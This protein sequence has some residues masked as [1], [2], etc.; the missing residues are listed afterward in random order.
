MRLPG[1]NGGLNSLT[2][3]VS[4][5]LPHSYHVIFFQ[6]FSVFASIQLASIMPRTPRRGSRGHHGL[7]MPKDS[8]STQHT[9]H[10]LPLSLNTPSCPSAI[11]TSSIVNTPSSSVMTYPSDFLE[12]SLAR[13]DS[14]SSSI[15]P[16]SSSLRNRTN[17]TQKANG[18]ACLRWPPYQLQVPRTGH[19]PM[20]LLCLGNDRLCLRRHA[21]QRATAFSGQ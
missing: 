17:L 7:C 12:S 19:D 4:P 8:L 18:R 21:Y 11:S 1:V 20:V 2:T 9:E 5:H 13:K 3:L 16:Y 10:P 14:T 15:T 6:T